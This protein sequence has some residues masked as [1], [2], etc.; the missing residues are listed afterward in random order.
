MSDITAAGLRAHLAEPTGTGPWPGVVVLHEALGLT[1]DVRGITDRIAQ[2]GYLAVAPDLFTDGGLLRCLKR[3][4]TD[5]TRG[6]GRAVEDVLAVTAWLRE[7]PDCTGKV[8]VVGF[9]MGGGFALLVSARGVDVVAPNYGP[10][11]TD[12]G[13]LD[14]ACPVVASY[15]ARDRF[16][17]RRIGPELSAALAE[18]GVEHDVKTYDGVGHS[19]LNRHGPFEALEK[20]LGLQYD[21]TV[22]TDAWQR[23]FRYFDEHLHG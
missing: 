23:I 4:F 8:G 14:G 9:C 10:V 5:L 17:P 13:A 11:P 6:S 19:F 22:A 21:E 1:R 15:G 7:R 3:V 20:V 16:M 2:R 12:L 18:R